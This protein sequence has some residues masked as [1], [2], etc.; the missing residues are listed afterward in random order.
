MESL[1]IICPCCNTALSI[2]RETGEILHH[3]ETKKGPADFSDFL[4]KQKSRKEDIARKFEESREKNQGRLKTIEEKIAWTKKKI[5][6][7]MHFCNTCF[8]LIKTIFNNEM[9]T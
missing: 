4:S 9:Q 5:E 3:E 6:S 7:I 8:A 2:S 1:N